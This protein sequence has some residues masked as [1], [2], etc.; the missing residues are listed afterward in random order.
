MVHKYSYCK[1]IFSR[2][3]A[4]IVFISISFIILTLHPHL[5]YADKVDIHLRG[6]ATG[7]S[8][9]IPM[10]I[11]E[12]LSSGSIN[13]YRLHELINGYEIVEI[14]QK[15]I[16][17]K[18]GEKEVRVLLSK[19][20]STANED[21]QEDEF[22]FY[23]FQK[24]QID[25]GQITTKLRPD[26]EKRDYQSIGVTVT[27]IKEGHFMSIMGIKEEDTILELNG[28]Q[29]N[30][31]ED[32]DVAIKELINKELINPEDGSIRIAFERNGEYQ[33]SYGD[34]Q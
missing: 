3:Q 14:Q 15:G 27:D 23:T 22:Q 4:C 9:D 20:V 24:D 13:S 31:P 29:I 34:M 10:A 16:L 32:L 19:E 1:N 21:Y 18:K 28:N 8:I 33:T 25:T 12:D 17:L 30:K 11:I 26:I 6:I 7:S 2:Q 5:S